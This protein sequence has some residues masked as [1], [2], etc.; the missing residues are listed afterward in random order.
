MTSRILK[1]LLIFVFFLISE[2]Y[3]A[4]ERKLKCVEVYD[5]IDLIDNQQ[6]DDAILILRNCEK[7]DPTDYT[8]PYEIA[9]AYTYKDQYQKAIDELLKVKQ[10]SNIK[11][12]YFQLLGN[13]YDYLGQSQKALQVYQEGLTRFPNAGR[14]YLEIGVVYEGEKKWL[15]AIKSY[16]KGIRVDPN[17]PSNYYRA[18][19][20]YLNSSDRL[21]GIIYGEI[22]LNIERTTKRSQEMS[23]LLYKAYQNSISFPKENEAKVDFCKVIIDSEKFEKSKKLPLCAVFG[24]NFILGVIDQKEVNLSSLSEMRTAFLIN[25]NK[26]DLQDYPNVLFSYWN[27]LYNK[28]YFEAYSHYLLQMGSR[29]EFSEWLSQNEVKYNAFVEWYTNSDNELNVS[30]QNVFVSDSIKE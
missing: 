22:F 17:Y 14:L 25:Y 3:L 11:S 6:Y 15:D 21:S 30:K 24:K 13:N 5:A 18:A 4:Q 1:L 23:E 2:K 9:L 12:D 7:N 29:T 8:Y 16:E 19:K 27:T 26:Q 28:G 20:I 10:Y